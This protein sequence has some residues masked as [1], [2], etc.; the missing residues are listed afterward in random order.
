MGAYEALPV[1][2]SIALVGTSPTNAASVQFT[3]TFSTRV[4]GVGASDFALTTSGPSGASVTSAVA[5]GGPAPAKVWTVT[6]NTGSGD[7]TLRLD[8]VDDDGITAAV[9]PSGSIPLGGTGPGNGGFTA[10]PSYSLDKTAPVTNLTSTPP[11]ASNGTN[12]SFGFSGSD[13]SGGAVTFEC[14]LGEA[15]FAAA[16]FLMDYLKTRAP[17]WKQVEK[18]GGKTWVEA[19]S[20]DDAAAE[21][22]RGRGQAAE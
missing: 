2:A 1:V 3:V 12:A 9:L 18:A 8:V 20:S 4:S 17:F 5:Q 14:S 7:G 11:T 22:W 6:V 16:E 13:A 10:G 19:K 21:R 15:A